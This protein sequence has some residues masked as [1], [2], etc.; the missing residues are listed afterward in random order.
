M[1][2]GIRSHVIDLIRPEYSGLSSRRLNNFGEAKSYRWIRRVCVSG[3]ENVL[4]TYRDVVH[5]ECK[6][7]GQADNG[8]QK[9]DT[10]ETHRLVKHDG[11]RAELRRSERRES[12]K[13]VWLRT[14]GCMGIVKRCKHAGR[15]W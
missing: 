11:N 14:V 9:P 13:A 6:C 8:L 4:A 7:A 5:K 12:C 15:G 2:Q 3:S 1:N 10:T